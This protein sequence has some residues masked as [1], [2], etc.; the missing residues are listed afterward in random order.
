M[1]S[2]NPKNS[3][4]H[5]S[6]TKPTYLLIAPVSNLNNGQK[7]SHNHRTNSKTHSLLISILN[8]R[9]NHVSLSLIDH[10]WVFGFILMNGFEN[11]FEFVAFRDFAIT[12]IPLNKV[13]SVLYSLLFI[14]HSNPVTISNIYRFF[15]HFNFINFLLSRFS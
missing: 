1:P 2:N 7:A 11:K 4:F 8:S 15:I 13:S 6:E 5:K 12:L 14:K 10:Q 3:S 9:E